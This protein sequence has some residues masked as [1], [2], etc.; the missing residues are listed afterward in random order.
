MDKSLNTRGNS[1]DSFGRYPSWIGWIGPKAGRTLI[2]V[3]VLLLCF[4]FGCAKA[5]FTAKIKEPKF[6]SRTYLE[7]PNAVYYAVRWALQTNGYPIESKN[8]EKGI[9]VSRWV[10][11]TPSSHAVQL[12]GRKDYGV[13]ASYHQLEIQIAAAEETG[14]TKVRIGSRIQ[15]MINRIH[16]T[17]TEEELILSKISDYLRDPES[18][19]TNMGLEEVHG[20]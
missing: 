11:V 13:T 2:A 6:Y 9:L 10:S 14:R 7:E 20:L 15:S 5:Q 12:F 19:V 4:Q 17:G 8:L 1:G 16:S 18:K 3:F